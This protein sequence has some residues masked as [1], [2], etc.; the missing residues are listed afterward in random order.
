M[1]Q[2]ANTHTVDFILNRAHQP[3]EVAAQYGQAAGVQHQPAAMVRARSAGG[4][5]ARI[6]HARGA[7]SAGG[8]GA[9][10]VVVRG[11]A[12]EGDLL[13]LPQDVDFGLGEAELGVG[14]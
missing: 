14:D 4:A 9:A 1:S 6:G 10:G 11:G 13:V 7:P 8:G 5:G 2:G 3:L 12:R